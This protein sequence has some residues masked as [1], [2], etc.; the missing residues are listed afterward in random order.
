MK[1]E[2]TSTSDN[3]VGQTIKKPYIKPELVAFHLEKN[4]SGGTSSIAESSHG[5][6]FAT[7]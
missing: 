7:S 6:L 1:T 2:D 3:Q 4:T 5:F